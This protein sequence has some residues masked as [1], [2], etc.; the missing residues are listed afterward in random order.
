[1]EGIELLLLTNDDLNDDPVLSNMSEQLRHHKVA[2]ALLT[3]PPLEATEEQ[4]W[5]CWG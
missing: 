3:N 5:S 4:I 1:M 2:Q